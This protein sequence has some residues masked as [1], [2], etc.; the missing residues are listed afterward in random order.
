MHK[1]DF[2][3]RDINASFF[4]VWMVNKAAVKARFRFGSN[5]TQQTSGLTTSTALQREWRRTCEQMLRQQWSQAQKAALSAIVS[6]HKSLGATPT[7][8]SPHASVE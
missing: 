6:F 2:G 8:L 3:H 5:L 7:S 1:A 4:R